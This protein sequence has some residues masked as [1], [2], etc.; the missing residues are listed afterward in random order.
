MAQNRGLWLIFIGTDDRLGKAGGF[1]MTDSV[2]W[3]WKARVL[4]RREMAAAGMGYAELAEALALQGLSL[5]PKV[6][7]NKINRGTFTMAFFMQ[8]MAICKVDEVKLR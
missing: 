7:S 3:C 5:T 6:L 2:E 4:L 1:V 8:C